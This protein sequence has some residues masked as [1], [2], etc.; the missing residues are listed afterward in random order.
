VVLDDA[1]Q[2]IAE[3]FDRANHHQDP[4]SQILDDLARH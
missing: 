1:I 3:E 4:L 2:S